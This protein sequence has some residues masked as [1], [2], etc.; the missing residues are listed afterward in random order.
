VLSL[1]FHS[2]ASSWC[3]LRLRRGPVANTQLGLD[4]MLA[5]LQGPSSA[6]MS[7]EEIVDILRDLRSTAEVAHNTLNDILLFDKIKS[8]LFTIDME[9]HR[10][11]KFVMDV[12]KPFR[13]QVWR[14][15]N[16]SVAFLLSGCVLCSYYLGTKLENSLQLCHER[17]RNQKS[18]TED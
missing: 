17:Y 16:C 3:Y 2:Y 4:L 11:L 18:E 8:N 5:S 12:I 15:V 9:T 13:M 1:R 10:A 6:Q 14:F 7:K